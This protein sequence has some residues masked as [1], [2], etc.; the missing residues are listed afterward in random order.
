MKKSDFHAAYSRLRFNII[1]GSVAIEVLFLAV[2]FVLLWERNRHEE[3]L[4]ES[5]Q[6]YRTL[7]TK[8][9]NGFALHEVVCD[10]A[11]KPHDYR[12]IEVNDSFEALTGL[13]REALVG[14]TVREVLP[15]IEEEW[16][17]RYGA[18][19]LTGQ[20]DHFEKYSRELD[21][22]YEVSAYSPKRESSP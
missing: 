4:R 16:I 20:P 14:R 22:W 3:L 7:F 12:F 9:L 11:G 8:M 13:K 21:R 15:G 18:V 1:A 2:G 17:E 6:K 5:E 10:P 19:A